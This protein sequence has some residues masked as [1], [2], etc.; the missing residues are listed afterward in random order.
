MCQTKGGSA[1]KVR[2]CSF[3]ARTSCPGVV[4]SKNTTN[5]NVTYPCPDGR[6]QDQYCACGY[7]GP[8]CSQCDSDYFSVWTGSGG[9][10]L[11]KKG[12]SHVPTV[13]LG[14][15]VFICGS[16]F[17]LACVK[18]IKQAFPKLKQL[19]RV[20]AVKLRVLF[21]AA[22]IISEFATI[23]SETGASKYPEP[24]STFASGTPE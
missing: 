4:Y 17:A 10:K 6:P 15:F 11:C 9:C 23:S 2:E 8:L 21:F 13:I 7:M 16:A 12:E 22:Q 1:L 3:S 19:W 18:A 14:I 5:K 20:G 24:A